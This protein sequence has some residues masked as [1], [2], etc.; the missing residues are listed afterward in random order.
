MLLDLRLSMIQMIHSWNKHSRTLTLINYSKLQKMIK[1]KTKKKIATESCS[2]TKSSLN[3]AIKNSQKLRINNLLKYSK[4]F[5]IMN[6]STWK[7]LSS[8]FKTS[9][10]KNNASQ[11]KT[12]PLRKNLMKMRRKRTKSLQNKKRKELILTHSRVRSWLCWSSILKSSRLFTVQS[13]EELK[14]ITNSQKG[15]CLVC[16]GK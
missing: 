2:H 8:I 6:S 14:L 3:T 9:K 4:N 16:F 5:S 11:I 12:L 1:T 10:S 7:I 13:L 15:Q